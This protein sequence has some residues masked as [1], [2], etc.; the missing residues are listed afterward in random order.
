MG[1]DLSQGEGRARSKRTPWR[2]K[3]SVQREGG[4]G[5]GEKKR[6]LLNKGK[7]HKKKRAQMQDS[8]QKGRSPTRDVQKGIQSGHR[9]APV[10]AKK[11]EKNND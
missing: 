3:G 2:R 4:V 5:G 1:G 9:S 7:P 6:G 10:R 11:K 8:P